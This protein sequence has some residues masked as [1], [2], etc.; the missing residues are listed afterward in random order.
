MH[1]K[2]ALVAVTILGLGSMGAL[3]LFLLNGMHGLLF[4]L[5]T[6]EV[7]YYAP[8]YS[9]WGF[10]QVKIGMSPQDVHKLL[11]DPLSEYLVKE[12][13]FTGWKY[14][15]RRTDSHYRGARHAFRGS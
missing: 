6:E 11:G 5:M 8:G 3:H 15:G 14:S 13:N 10:R 7:T 12:T 2:G 9:D 1:I 4:D